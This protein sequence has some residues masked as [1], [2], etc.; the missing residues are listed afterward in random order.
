[1]SNEGDHGKIHDS[2][3]ARLFV[4]V[5]DEDR[6][7]ATMET[8]DKGNAVLTLLDVNERPR[9]EL[10]VGNDGKGL[11][12]LWDASSR[13]RAFMTVDPRS[14]DFVF[15]ALDGTG[16]TRFTIQVRGDGSAAQLGLGGKELSVLLSHAEGRAG[17]IITCDP[18]GE[19]KFCSETLEDDAETV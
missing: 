13:P 12:T 18:D 17:R 1:M 5:D 9:I 2:L 19:V 14:D 8:R 10:G 3:T 15:A 16:E 6:T 4:L 11:I 7:R